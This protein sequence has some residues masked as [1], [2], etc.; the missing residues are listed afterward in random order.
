MRALKRYLGRRNA[1]GLRVDTVA[2][3]AAVSLYLD[4]TDKYHWRGPCEYWT[5]VTLAWAGNLFLNFVCC[6]MS[7]TFGAVKFKAAATN[8]M[9]ISWLAAASQTYLIIEPLQARPNLSSLQS[10]PNRVFHLIH[11]PTPPH[12]IP[13]TPFYPTP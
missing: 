12:P 13:P 8:F 10:H 4:K 9:L 1:K 11:H 7:L 3:A 6:I 2:A 5:R